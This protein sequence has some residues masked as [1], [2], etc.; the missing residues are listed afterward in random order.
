VRQHS[1][2]FLVDVDNTL[3]DN[4]RIRS[5]IH[6]HFEREYG[7]ACGDR[8]WAIQEQLFVD[9]GYR[10]YLGAVQ[11]Y[12]LE[13]SDDLRSLT[14]AAYLLDY[15]FADR[16]YPHALDVLERFS[17]WGTT[18]VLTDGDAVFQ[19]H[20]VRRSGIDEAVGGDVLVYVHKEH[21]LDDV[22]RR[23]P[24]GHYVVVDDKLRILTAVREAWGER[25]TTVFP[26][27]GQFAHDPEEIAS[28]PPADVTVERIGDLLAYDLPDLLGSDG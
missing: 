4:D 8:Y 13:H 12:W 19:P 22:A 20:K 3:L 27:Q 24:A 28:N 9:L 6:E 25:V 11:R 7:P 2:V 14:M 18:V 10:D 15:P 16:V 17:A 1:V 21:E 5:D 26:R 23:Y